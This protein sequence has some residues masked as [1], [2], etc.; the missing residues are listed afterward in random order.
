MSTV[1]REEMEKARA[2]YSD[3]RSNYC[4]VHHKFL[5]SIL[6]EA[7]VYEKLVVLKDSS[8]KGQFQI[9]SESY[10]TNRPWT[11]KFFPVRTTYGG[12]SMKS[13][14]IPNFYPWEEDTLVQ[15]LKDICEV[16][17]DLP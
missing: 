12:I 1:T 5:T 3:A 16:V 7:G 15:Q 14:S 13:K 17:G 9:A 2:V 8:L 6:K 11:I 4:L 10:N